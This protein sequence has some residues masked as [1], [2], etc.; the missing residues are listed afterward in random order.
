MAPLKVL[1]LLVPLHFVEIVIILVLL[2]E[3]GAVGTILTVVPGMVVVTLLIVIAFFGGACVLRPRYDGAV[4]STNPLEIKNR[5]T[6]LSSLGIWAVC[7]PFDRIG[8][9]K[10][11]GRTRHCHRLRVVN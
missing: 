8:R 3:I 2:L 1:L 10:S 7:W 6:S 5:C 11:F 4:L 9:H